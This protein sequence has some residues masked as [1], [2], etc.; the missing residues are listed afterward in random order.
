MASLKLRPVLLLAS[1]TGA[2]ALAGCQAKVGKTDFGGYTPQDISFAPTFVAI[3]TCGIR[4]P[5]DKKRWKKSVETVSSSGFP[6]T[7]ITYRASEELGSYT[8]KL[9]SMFRNHTVRVSYGCDPSNAKPARILAAFQK[10]YRSG[11]NWRVEWQA[12]QT[13]QHDTLGTIHYAPYAEVYNDAS[14]SSGIK[15]YW[16]GADGSILTMDTRIV[17]HAQDKHL[18]RKQS[19]NTNFSLDLLRQ[20]TP[21]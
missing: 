20:I 3:E 8:R 11:S 18:A 15:A 16:T 6:A 7:K 14:R 21:L 2:L 10:R 5:V 4:V 17:E 1:L 9:D 19:W 13:L 12:A